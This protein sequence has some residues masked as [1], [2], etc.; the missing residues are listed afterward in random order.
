MYPNEMTIEPIYSPPEHDEMGHLDYLLARLEELRDRGLIT[1]DSYAT[2]ANESQARRAVIERAGRYAAAVGQA[3]T[4][5]KSRPSEALAWAECARG[6]DPARVDA[7][8]LLVDL[9]WGLEEDEAAILRCGEAAVR[10]PQLR[11]R[12]DELRAEQA[13]RAERRRR[14]AALAHQEHDVNA[15]VAQA[16]K[17]L[18]QS[19]DPEAIA[20]CRQ[21]LD[22]RPA[23]KDA[24]VMAAYALQRVGRLDQALQMYEALERLEPRNTNW[25]VWARNVRLRRGVQKVTGSSGAAPDAAG[26]ESRP[27]AAPRWSETVLPPPLSW[28]SFTGEFLQ[29]HWQKL[30]LCLAVLLIVVS[31][32]V[33]AHLLLGD[34]LWSSEGKCALALVATLLFASLGAGLLRWGAGRAG[35]M[36]LIATLIV[37]PIH[38]MLAGEMRLLLKPPS[39]RHVFLAFDALVLVAM[40]RW[41]SGMLARRSGARFLTIALVLLSIGSAATTRGSSL[42]WGLQFASFQLS[43]VVFLVSVWI[44]G[45]RRWGASDKDH[46]DFAYMMLGLLGFA[47]VSCL[48]RTG[49]YA[50]RLETSLYG[51]PLMLGAISCVH[52]ARRLV[53]YEPDAQRLA[54]MRLGGYALSGL[55]FALILSGTLAASALNSGNSLAVAIL[56][57]ALYASS[58]R[59]DRHPAFLYLAVG[60]VVAG[61]LG[62][63]YF[64]AERLHAIEEAVRQLLGYPDHLPIPFRAILGLIPNTILAWL[65]LWFVKNWDDRRLARHCHYI[66]VPLSIAACVWSGFEPLAA[67]ICLSGYALLYLWAVWAFAAPEVTYLAVAALGGAAYFASTRVPGITL[68]GQALMTAAIGMGCWL[69]RVVLGRLRAGEAFRVPWFHA[70]AA[71]VAVAMAVATLHLMSVGIGSASAAGSF[72]LVTAVALLL[73]RDRPRTVWPHLAC[74]SFVELTM[75]ALGLA[76]AGKT[77]APHDFGLLFMAD[78]LIVLAVAEALRLLVRTAAARSDGATDP[79][80]ARTFLAAVPRFT[81]VLTAVAVWVALYDIDRT[82]LTGLVF[83]LGSAT[84]LWTARLEPW[85]ALVYVGLALLLAG[86]FDIS[87]WTIGW[88]HPALLAGWLAITAGWLALALWTVAAAGRRFGLAELY[89]APC[90][91]V[92]FALTVI[93]FVGALDARFL[94]REA[95]PHGVAALALNLLVTMLL[96]RTWRRADLT[97]AALFHVVTATYVVLFSIGHNDPEMAYVLGLA[98]AGEALVLWT[99]GFVCQRARDDWTNECAPPL[100]HWSLFL[101]ALA[102]PLSDRSPV[103]LAMVGLSF[104]LAV[105]SLPRTEWLYGTVASVG[106]AGYFRWFSQVSPIEL[107]EVAVG[108]AFV[109]WGLGVLIQRS[110]PSLCRRLRMRPL[111]YEFPLFHSSIAVGLIALLLRIDLSVESNATWTAHEWLPLG[112]SCLSLVMLRAYPRRECVHVSLAFL[113]WCVVAAIVPSLTSVCWLTLAGLVL[114]LAFLLIERVVRPIEPAIC[115]RVGVIEAGYGSVVRGWSSAIFGLATGLAILVVVQEMAGVMAGLRPMPLALSSADWW[116]MLGALGLIGAFL[117]T[118]GTDPEGW[119]LMERQHEVIALHWLSVALLWWL[120]VASSPLAGRAVTTGIYYPLVTGIAALAT[121]QLFRRSTL[122]ESWH[123]LRW[124]GDLGT[125]QLEGMLSG[126]ACLLAVLAAWF[127][128][129]AVEP[130][131]V[132]TLILASLTLG[133]VALGSGWDGAA[134]SGSL[135]WTSAWGFA[136][137]VAAQRW[138]WQAAEPRMTCAA[139]GGLVAAF[140]LWALAGRARRDGSI[141]KRTITSESG[142]SAS[143]GLRLAQAVEIGAFL[144]SLVAAAAVLTAGAHPPAVPGWE[145]AAGVAVL[146][147]AALLHI[148]LVPRWQGEWLVYLAQATMLGAY[149]L[150]RLAFPQPIATDAA[151]LTGLGYLDLGIAEVLER[152]GRRTYVRPTRCFSFLLPVLPLFQLIGIEGIDDVSLFYLLAAATFY[153]VAFGQLRWKPLSYAA[154]VFYNAALWV[155]WSQLRWTITDHFQFFIVPVGLSTILFAQVNRRDLSRQT[156][157][158]IRSAGLMIVYV[159]LAVPIWQYESFGAWV[160]LLLGS[161]AGV[162]LGIG[163]RLQTFLWMGLATFVLDV[164]YEMGRVSLDFAEAKWAIMLSLGIALVLFVALNEKKGIVAAMRGYYDQARLWE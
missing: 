99:I 161:L 118:A 24:L 40:V 117:V 48:F 140:S 54:L 50:M 133:L 38:F 138:G 82:R 103:V 39:L 122:S 42:A 29:E 87:S 43:P 77:L 64:L 158:T 156:V 33:G 102:I 106:A 57:L 55:A 144:T 67:I 70:A 34:L 126:S 30:I 164:I 5:A 60:A 13:E 62:A 111:A 134:F 112:L 149:V 8:D 151:I 128:K 3:R 121:A 76:T 162:F 114:A 101:T 49:S 119:G 59:D 141:D 150:Y 142:S 100:Y 86:T 104:L 125:E 19:R 32:T 163:M 23:H 145:T 66:G 6:I 14:N 18:E 153:G 110:K 75:C 25:T 131:T 84:L 116:A 12:L 160:V 4:L 98:A 26:P 129:G 65:A 58:L 53:P 159:A 90:L 17:L 71:A 44:L 132:L 11:P 31:S 109:L 35:R 95:Y 46:L 37:V 136:G 139:V 79:A 115:A 143:S 69:M 51:L 89:N 146:M 56:G 10:F 113:T 152:F 16:R 130:V 85:R 27:A 73:N 78:G 63:H 124:L 20:L 52:A 15:W 81:I 22:L 36:M 147:G 91:N 120:G 154:G 41:V 80:W 72:A 21:V 74:V 2:V 137:L 155:L 123:E 135:A 97:Y 93:A 68:A 96:A 148:L 7:W 107:I 61:R 108:A 127:T 1:P 47:L 157:N 28:S 88:S 92:A 94:G 83:L 9:N 45:A 105:K